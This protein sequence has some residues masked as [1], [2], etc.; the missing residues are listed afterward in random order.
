MMYRGGWEFGER[1]FGRIYKS[2]DVFVR[3]IKCLFCFDKRKKKLMKV[4]VHF[5]YIILS[6]CNTLFIYVNFDF[7]S[8]H[9]IKITSFRKYVYCVL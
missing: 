7:K 3:L 8:N 6:K 5:E 1:Y 2:K 4:L 9:I